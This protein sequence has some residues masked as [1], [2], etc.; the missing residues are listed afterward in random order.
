[1]DEETRRF[2]RSWFAKADEDLYAAEQL[3]QN[4]RHV[5]VTIVCFHCQQCAER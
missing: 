5:P 1:M 4:P 3:M 2:A